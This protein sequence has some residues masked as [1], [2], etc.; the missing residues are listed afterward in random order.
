[1]ISRVWRGWTSHEKADAYEK[2][3]NEEII[4]AIAA[5]K[6]PGYRSI[7]V[8]RRVLNEREVEFMTIMRFDSLQSIK[9]FV[10]EDYEVA[11][12]PEKARQVLS[13][14]D[15]RSQHFQERSEYRY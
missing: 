6:M 13:R 11:H 9:A 15:S 8:Y 7:R 4:P 1:M 12:V 3:L 10:G 5:K 14:F 2:L